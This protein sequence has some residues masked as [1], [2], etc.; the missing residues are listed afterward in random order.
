MGKYDKLRDYLINADGDNVHLSFTDIEH[1]IQN[2]LPHSART[3]EAWWLWSGG[4]SQ[5]KAWESA[6]FAVSAVDLRNEIAEF[7]RI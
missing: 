3:Y 5:D 7:K 1:I 4:R 6:G 2:N